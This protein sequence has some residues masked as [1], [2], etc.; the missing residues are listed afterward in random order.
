MH[1]GKPR[2]NDSLKAFAEGMFGEA[3]DQI[4]IPPIPEKETLLKV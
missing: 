4:Q 2:T 3:A 1:T